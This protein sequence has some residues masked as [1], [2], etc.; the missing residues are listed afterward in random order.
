MNRFA[1]ALIT[2]SLIISYPSPALLA[3]QS[4]P[5]SAQVGEIELEDTS[6]V[7]RNP[8]QVGQD[9]A[10]AYFQGFT[11]TIEALRTTGSGS[12]EPLSEGAINHLVGVYLYCTVRSGAC[13][14]VLDA[15]LEIDVVNA[16]NGEAQACPNMER[17]WKAWVR[18]D[19][20]KRQNFLVRTAH[21]NTTSEFT[22]NKRPRYLKC[23]ETVQVEIGKGGDSKTFFASRYETGS[24]PDE[25]VRKLA[26]FL[27]ELKAKVPNTV[28]AAERES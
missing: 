19:M 3:Q 15:I 24:G 12:L 16:K 1:L 28:E 8:Y 5:G 13:P 6:P 7:R 18:S 23:R 17:F 2:V 10:V 9:S 22:R 14:L 26:A 11:Q 21:M 4:A 20:E 27:T 25:Q